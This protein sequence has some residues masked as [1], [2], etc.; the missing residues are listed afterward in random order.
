MRP[1]RKRETAVIDKLDMGSRGAFKRCRH[2]MRGLHGLES[3]RHSPMESA[4]LLDVPR[5]PCLVSRVVAEGSSHKRRCAISP[6]LEDFPAAT[7]RLLSSPAAC[8]ALR[9]FS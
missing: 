7:G 6:Y 4:R 1:A 9:S 3:Y 8:I 2:L 5:R